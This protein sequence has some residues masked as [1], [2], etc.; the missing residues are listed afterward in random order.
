M[1]LDPKREIWKEQ[2]EEIER[3]QRKEWSLALLWEGELER[4]QDAWKGAVWGLRME[5]WTEWRKEWEWAEGKESEWDLWW[6]LDSDTGRVGM[7]LDPKREVWKEKRK[8]IERGQRREEQWGE[9]KGLSLVLV[10][11]G[12]WDTRRGSSKDKV[13]D[14][15]K[16]VLRE[17]RLEFW[18]EEMRERESG[19]TRGSRWELL[20]GSEW[21]TGKVSSLV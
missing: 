5:V 14:P 3:E 10:W 2:R 18:K 11:G 19:E 6:E 8:E 12:E 20:W 4:R 15:R 7:K 17:E 1:E 13:L 16:A 9:A 21:G